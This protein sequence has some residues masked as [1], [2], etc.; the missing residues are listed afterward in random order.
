MI[1]P[2]VMHELRQCHN[3]RR[4]CEAGGDEAIESL[5]NP[6]LVFAHLRGLAKRQIHS[7]N[8]MKSRRFAQLRSLNAI[9][10]STFS[11]FFLLATSSKTQIDTQTPILCQKTFE[12]SAQ[13]HGTGSLHTLLHFT[14]LAF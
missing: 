13:T 4:F 12:T 9:G 11:E 5:Y 1:I 14:F 6:Q 2:A 8:V 10:E 3:D 7:T